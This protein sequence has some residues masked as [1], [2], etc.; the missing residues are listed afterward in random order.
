MVIN[1]K[2]N[3]HSKIK[4]IMLRSIVT[5]GWLECLF[6]VITFKRSF[7]DKMNLATHRVRKERVLQ[8]KEKVSSKALR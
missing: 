8:V 2:K 5:I 4:I 3:Q 7:I 1:M 6:E